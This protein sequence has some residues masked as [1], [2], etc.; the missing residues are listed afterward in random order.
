M[1]QLRTTA[2]GDCALLDAALTHDSYVFERAGRSALSSNER[3][4]YLG[5]AVLGLAASAWLYKRYPRENEGVLSRRRQALVSRA[6][7]YRSAQRIELAALLRLGK[8]EAAGGGAR[9]PSILAA[10][11][12]ALTG[13]VFLCEGYE[14]AA[15]FIERAHLVHA[16]P[17]AGADARTTLQELAQAKFKKA[18]QYALVSE[19]GPAHARVFKARVSI[20]NVVGTGSGPTKKQAQADAAAD[21]LKQLDAGT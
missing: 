6:A 20:G 11:F 1:L 19:S 18:P 8:G 4:E 15:R 3:L 13:A 2:A 7:L 5:D 21:A 17:V 12:E 14:S 9:R 16:E 10:A